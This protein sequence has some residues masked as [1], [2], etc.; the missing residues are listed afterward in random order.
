[1][2]KSEPHG[3]AEVV[4]INDANFRE[5]QRRPEFPRPRVNYWAPGPTMKLRDFPGYFDQFY[6]YLT[7]RDRFMVAQVNSDR[8][9]E[10]LSR[11][12]IRLQHLLDKALTCLKSDCD[13][14]HRL[15]FAV[16]CGLQLW[17]EPASE[18]WALWASS[19]GSFFPFSGR[20]APR[21]TS[22]KAASRLERDAE[23][24]EVAACG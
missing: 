6:W 23:E 8:A 2:S 12:G 14:Q 4:E 13:M 17:K 3:G 9:W 16:R 20:T 24:G 11:R 7:P 18:A 19:V 1:M 15:F 22:T 21:I 5:M 10:E